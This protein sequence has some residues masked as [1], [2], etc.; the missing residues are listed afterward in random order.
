MCGKQL[1]SGNKVL[2]F[3][4]GQTQFAVRLV[5]SHSSPPF[6]V[7]T[8]IG[9]KFILAAAEFDSLLS[10]FGSLALDS[11][12]S[13][14]MS[15]SQNMAPHPSQLDQVVQALQLALHTSHAT[16]AGLETL[17]QASDQTFQHF[18]AARV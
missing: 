16:N 12:N 14:E 1:L 10:Q 6:K 11:Q 8:S 18:E 2:V 17:R 5:G 15:G 4:I 13:S 3:S 9:F 7:A